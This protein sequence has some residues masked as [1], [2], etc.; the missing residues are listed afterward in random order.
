M[1]HA[2]P[3]QIAAQA[4]AIR[5]YQGE[6]EQ[7]FSRLFLAQPADA[8]RWLLDELGADTAKLDGNRV[9]R[10]NAAAAGLVKK[11]KAQVAQAKANMLHAINNELTAHGHSIL[12][13]ILNDIT[14]QPESCLSSQWM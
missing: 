4:L 6:V 12:P 1:Q 3:D 10:D 9:R 11:M 5:A 2:P 7:L 8:Q 13:N 14:G